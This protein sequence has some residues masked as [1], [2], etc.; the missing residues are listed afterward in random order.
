MTTS[1]HQFGVS[2]DRL[3]FFLEQLQISRARVL[4][5]DLCRPGFALASTGRMVSIG[6]LT[7][8]ICYSW[9][10]SE[11]IQIKPSRNPLR[12]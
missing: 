12:N 8:P 10:T 7:A 2:A 4:E 9:P 3:T 6:G 11:I 1:E 5:L